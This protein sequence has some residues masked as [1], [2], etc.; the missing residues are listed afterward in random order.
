M[1]Q[2]HSLEADSY[3]PTHKLS[4]LFCN[5]KFQCPVHSSKSVVHTLN[6]LS[7]VQIIMPSLLLTFLLHLVNNQVIMKNKQHE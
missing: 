2:K 6:Q 5:C 3:S 4:R 7:S 1:Q